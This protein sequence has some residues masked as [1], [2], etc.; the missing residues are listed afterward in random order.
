MIS[1]WTQNTQT[2]SLALAEMVVAQNFKGFVSVCVCV[3]VAMNK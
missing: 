1:T 3:C 2:L